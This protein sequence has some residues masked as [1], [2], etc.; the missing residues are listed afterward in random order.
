[1]RIE[2]E[3]IM[4][5]FRM[6]YIWVLEELEEGVF[7]MGGNDGKDFRRDVMNGV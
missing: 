1:M 3:G 5:I 7:K 4:V 2:R 6:R